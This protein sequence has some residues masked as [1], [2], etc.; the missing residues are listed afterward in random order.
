MREIKMEP[1]LHIGRMIQRQLKASGRTVVWF[2]D[3][4]CCSRVNVYKIFKKDNIDIVLL[5]R[6]CKILDH[7]FFHDISV[8]AGI[9]AN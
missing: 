5:I 8:L 3:Q 9:V 4:L 6:I 1:T 7:D 2:A